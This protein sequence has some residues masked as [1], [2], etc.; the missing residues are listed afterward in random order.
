M[1]VANKIFTNTI[2]Q[3]SIRAVNIL[4][5]VFSIALITRMF[6]ST[7]Y[8]FYT[9]TTAFVQ[10]FMILA[11][12]GLYLTLLREISKAKDGQEEN[13][14]INNI[15]TIRVLFS[16]LVLILIPVAIQFFPYAPIVKTGVIYFMG[17]L[18]FQSL[19]TTITAV[20]SKKL[21]MHKV[22]ITDL[23]QK[24]FYFAGLVY[25]FYNA[26]SLNI[27]LGAN[28]IT[29]GIGFLI[30][31]YFLRKHT[32]LRLAW[33]FAYWKKIFYVAWP[34]AIT[35]VLNLLYFKADTLVLSGFHSPETV[36]IYGAPYRVLEVISTFPHMFLSL[37][38]P[39]LTAAW[40]NKNT[41]KFNEIL[42][43]NFDFFSILIMG[44]IALLLLISK[45]LMITL[46]GEEFAASG[47]ILN[48]LV[49][50]TASIFYGTLFT[51]AIVSLGKQ[52]QMVKYFLITAVVGML[53]ILF[54]FLHFLIGEPP[55]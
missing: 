53:D 22:A 26:N 36:G 12:L 55:A 38:L 4:I 27:I 18:F 16:I 33:D 54:L 6:G 9:T 7:G 47:P 41:K 3:M 5:G 44:M 30:I 43:H 11:D 46:A 2:W 20:F 52:K 17:A 13:K 42:Q 45:P 40:V 51:Y 48:L 31:L 50:A 35:V 10:I 28:S 37:I 14:I 49:V 19:I 8:G 39:L 25:F 1:S 34:L 32:K 24:V 15:F 29:T 21:E 23:V